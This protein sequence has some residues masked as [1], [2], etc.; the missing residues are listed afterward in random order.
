MRGKIAKDIDL[1]ILDKEVGFIPGGET[2]ELLRKKKKAW[3]RLNWIQ[4]SRR[5]A[6]LRKVR[7]K[8]AKDN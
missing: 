4:K 6:I 3:N 2:T 7:A 1:L 5:T 8:D